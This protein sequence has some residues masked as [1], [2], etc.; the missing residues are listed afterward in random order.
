MGSKVILL[1]TEKMIS[2]SGL[3]ITID[4]TLYSIEAAITAVWD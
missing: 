3:F 4:Q 1:R 2:F